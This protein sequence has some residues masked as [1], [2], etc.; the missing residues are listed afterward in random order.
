MIISKSKVKIGKHFSS[1]ISSLEDCD[2]VCGISC[3]PSKNP[4]RDLLVFSFRRER[5]RKVDSLLGNSS[6]KYS[7]SHS[8]H[9]VSSA[10][11]TQKWELGSAVNPGSP[12]LLW[13]IQVTE[14]SHQEEPLLPR[15]CYFLSDQSFKWLS[16]ILPCWETK[17]RGRKKRWNWEGP[18]APFLPCWEGR[19]IL[20]HLGL[21]LTQKA[22]T[23]T[24]TP[25]CQQMK[26]YCKGVLWHWYRQAVTI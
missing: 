26:S 9:L 3:N 7:C 20:C 19:R 15:T 6:R 12:A 16:K 14:F 5:G 17:K 1:L 23:V 18:A 25:G 2:L 24:W 4:K 11:S 8:C 21:I 13:F 10:G 22:P